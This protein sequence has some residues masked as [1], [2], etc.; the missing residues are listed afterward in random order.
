MEKDTLL[1]IA[2]EAAIKAG[3]EIMMVYET[4]F[5]VQFKSDHSPLTVADERAH[6][7][8]HSY[9]K[10]THIP[11]I[12]EEHKQAPYEERKHWRTCWMVDPLDGTKEF[13]KRNGEFTVNIA[14]IENGQPVM[15]VIYVPVLKTLYYGVVSDGV[16]Y[17]IS[18]DKAVYSTAIFKDKISIYPKHEDGKPLRV[19]GSRSHKSR[20]TDAFIAGLEQEGKSVQIVSKGSSL[21]FCLMAEGDADMYPRFVPTMEW[22]TAAGHGICSAVGLTVQRID[23]GEPLQYNKEDLLNPYFLVQ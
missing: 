11:V 3:A 21:K 8:I 20:E 10:S 16:A 12:S 18:L 14:L 23:T 6:Q 13:I 5:E 7:I 22:D 15:G 9:L 19:I 2:V 4:S 17:K 1:A